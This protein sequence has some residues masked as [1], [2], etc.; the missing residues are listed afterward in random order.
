MNVDVNVQY[1]RVMF[2]KLKNAENNIIDVT[3]SRSL[4]F[5]G[6]MQSSGPVDRNIAVFVVELNSCLQRRS[7]VN[8]TKIEDTIEY[9]AGRT[10]KLGGGGTCVNETRLTNHH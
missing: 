9:R 5:F 2:K 3:E 7:C 6:V 4:K 1:T 8:R 10:S